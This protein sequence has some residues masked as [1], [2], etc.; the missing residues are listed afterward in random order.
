[1]VQSGNQA[2]LGSLHPGVDAPRNFNNSLPL[3]RLKTCHAAGEKKK[4]RNLFVSL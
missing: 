1:L 2:W 3:H 4:M